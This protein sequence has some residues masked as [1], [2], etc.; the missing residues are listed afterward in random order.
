MDEEEDKTVG[1]VMSLVF[2]LI[3]IVFYELSLG[4][5][6]W[7]YCAEI[8]TENGLT[9]ASAINQIF[10][11]VT[12]FGAPLLSKYLKG[13]TF[14]ACALSSLLSGFFCLFVLK[15]TKGLSESAIANLYRKNGEGGEE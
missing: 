7:V 11:V 5:L 6:K 10:T 13:Y 9:L 14:I 2:L 1:G 15:E 8:M 12:I 4:P 3:F